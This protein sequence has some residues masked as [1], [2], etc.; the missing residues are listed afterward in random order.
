MSSDQGTLPPHLAEIV[1]DFQLIQGREKLEYLLQFSEA[2]PPLP[3]RL[4]EQRAQFDQVHECMTP[5]FVFAE[6]DGDTIHYHFDVPQES[7]TVRGFAEILRV[8]TRGLTPREVIDIPSEFYLEMG[9]QDVLSGQRF[10]GMGAI[11]R[12]IQKLAKDELDG[13][14]A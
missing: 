6:R 12:H 11:L 2:L 5:V 1:E 14:D 8:G 4:Q 13:S 3:E 9:L 10:N 7:P